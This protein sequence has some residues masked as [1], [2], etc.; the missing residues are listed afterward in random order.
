MCVLKKEMYNSHR[1]LHYRLIH[2]KLDYIFNQTERDD[3]G[4]G[5]GKRLCETT[6]DRGSNVSKD[7]DRDLMI[8]EAKKI[9][10]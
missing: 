8:V 3:R 4:R 1:Q 5:L 2:R 10:G 6:I 9:H 7:I